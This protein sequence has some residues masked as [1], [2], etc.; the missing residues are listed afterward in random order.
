M[1]DRLSIYKGA[2]RLLGPSELAS[3]TEDR[4]ER[5]KLDDAWQS[6]VERML[7]RGLWNFAIRTVE[8]GYAE[9]VEPLFGF[10]HAFD[11]PTDWIRTVSIAPTANFLEGIQNY[12]DETR[13]WH[14]DF[15]TI[16]VRYVSNDDAYGWN[17]GAWREPFAEALEAYLAYTCGLPISADKGNRNDL[18]Q[19]YKGL[20]KDAKALDAVDEKVDTYPP[21]RWTRSRNSYQGRDRRG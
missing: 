3:L 12:E 21:G 9:D 6:A 5:H 13:Y 8:I 11:K 18:Y 15:E 4:P 19:L 7:S 10:Q 14:T 20:L 1:A 2:L 17:V 16:Y